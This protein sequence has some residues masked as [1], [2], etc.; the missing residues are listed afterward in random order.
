MNPENPVTIVT[1]RAI[2]MAGS[3][4]TVTASAEQIPSTSTV[5]GLFLNNGSVNIF[6]SIAYWFTGLVVGTTVE[7]ALAVES[8]TGRPSAGA[9]LAA[10][11][12]YSR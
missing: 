7:S 11:L 2:T 8:A 1:E 6:L 3:S 4:L 9:A 12:K 10:I 5:T